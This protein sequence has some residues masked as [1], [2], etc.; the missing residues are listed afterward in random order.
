MILLLV[1]T[2]AGGLPNDAVICAVPRAIGSGRL[3]LVT[4][5]AT[6]MKVCDHILCRAIRADAIP[7]PGPRRAREAR[8]RSRPS[9][10]DSWA[11]TADQPCMGAI[12]EMLS[13]STSCAK[14]FS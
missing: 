3:A 7:H 8:C 5:E 6:D 11:A 10:N 12:H 13:A 14:V 4:V 1:V 9:P 2:R